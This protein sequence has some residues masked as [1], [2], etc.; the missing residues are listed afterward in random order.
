M[1]MRRSDIYAGREGRFIGDLMMMIMMRFCTRHRRFLMQ[2]RR[3]NGEKSLQRIMYYNI[4]EVTV[5][6]FGII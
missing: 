4:I 3:P 1:E 5:G 2:G 6:L